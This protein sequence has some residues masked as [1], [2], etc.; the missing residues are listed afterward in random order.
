MMADH[1][2]LSASGSH[3]WLHCPGSVE[4]EKNLPKSSSPYA[5][6]GT[7]AH[8]LAEKCLTQSLYPESFLG[9]TVEGI[10]VDQEMIDAV[11]DYIDTVRIIGG[12]QVYEQRIDLSEWIE[13]GFGTADCVALSAKTLTVVDF[14]YGKGVKVDAKDNSQLKLYALG[15]Y[16]EY[17]LFADIQHVNM[18]IVQPRIEHCSEFTV[19]VKDL[20]AWG[21]W[22]KERAKQALKPSAPR[23]AGDSQCRWCRAKA[24]CPALYELTAKTVQAEFDDLDSVKPPSALSDDDLKAV[25]TN[26][27]LIESWLKA[28]EDHVFDRVMSGKPFK[29]YKI[30]EGRSF[31]Q[32]QD[33]NQA[34]SRLAELLGDDAYERSLLSVA[35]AEKRLG[36][37]QA[38]QIAHLVIKPQGK[39]VLVPDSD[40]R[41]SVNPSSDDFDTIA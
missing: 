16:N 1:A 8:A 17:G 18:V 38:A 27:K 26:R 13:G 22:V 33:N 29:G 7:G 30:V 4:A 35:K 40:K 32:W 12:Q 20:L 28:V 37:K 31:R 23:I 6:E 2:K 39:P 34:A 10:E 3:R 25:M 24:T 15:A 11:Q 21:D 19:S 14:K 9:Q 41:Q 5:N 36:K